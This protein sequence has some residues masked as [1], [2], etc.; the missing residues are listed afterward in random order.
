M[1]KKKKKID[2]KGFPG[3]M[4]MNLSRTF[5]ALNYELLIREL[6][7]CGF[8]VSSQKLLRVYLSSR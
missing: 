4:L 6:C 8:D 5:D 1:K 2:N 7:A 3:A